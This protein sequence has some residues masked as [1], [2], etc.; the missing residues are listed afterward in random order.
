[1]TEKM[2]RMIAVAEGQ[3]SRMPLVILLVVE[4]KEL[5]EGFMVKSFLYYYYGSP[6]Q[7]GP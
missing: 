5:T 7:L 3:G 2:R 4:S 6:W 1:M